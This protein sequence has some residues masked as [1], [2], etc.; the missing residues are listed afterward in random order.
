MGLRLAEG[1]DPARYQELAGRPLDSKC[2]AFLTETGFLEHTL[3]GR[4]RVTPSGFPVLDAV[5]ADLAA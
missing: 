1:I 4:L 2:I 5:V 3:A